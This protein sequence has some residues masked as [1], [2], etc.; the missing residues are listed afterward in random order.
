MVMGDPHHP[1]RAVQRD[2][3]VCP[4][5][6]CLCSIAK[7]IEANS[8]SLSCDRPGS[9]QRRL[10]VVDIHATRQPHMAAACV[11]LHHGPG[12]RG[13]CQVAVTHDLEP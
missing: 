3:D 12:R 1:P 4:V 11:A 9:L 8:N 5:K 6:P 13:E 7:S 2:Q 10:E